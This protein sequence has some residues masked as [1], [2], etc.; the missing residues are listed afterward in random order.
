MTL[1]ECGCLQPAP[2]AKRNHRGLGYVKGQP[3]RFIHGHS[4]RP[5]QP[6]H[7]LNVGKPCS[8]ET[9]RKISESRLA[10]K[11]W[12]WNGG[13][14]IDGKGYVRVLVGKEHPMAN[15][16]GYAFKHRLIVADDIG[17]MLEPQEEVD[18]IDGDRS[19]NE[20]ENLGLHPDHASHMAAHHARRHS[21]LGWA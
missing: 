5:F 9:R 13:E 19:N 4:G 11:H 12:N 14:Y 3:K 1:C 8:T 17:R 16:K 7:T 20:L 18:H 21:K 15:T 10:D 2:I 6:G